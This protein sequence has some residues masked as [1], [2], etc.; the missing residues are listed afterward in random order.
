MEKNIVAMLKKRNWFEHK[1][2]DT[3]K[4]IIVSVYGVWS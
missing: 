3:E 1:Y 2:Y 4:Q